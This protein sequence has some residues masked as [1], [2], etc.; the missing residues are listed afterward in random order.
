MYT[1]TTAQQIEEIK[2][3][4]AQIVHLLQRYYAAIEEY[5]ICHESK[6]QASFTYE[7]SLR[8]ESPH[9]ALTLGHELDTFVGTNILLHLPQNNTLHLNSK[10][11]TH[12]IDFI[13]SNLEQHQPL[14]HTPY[15]DWKIIASLYIA[16]Q[17]AQVSNT[18]E[19]I[20]KLIIQGAASYH[21]EFT[22]LENKLNALEQKE[23]LSH[24]KPP[25]KQKMTK[26]MKAIIAALSLS[27]AAVGGFGAHAAYENYQSTRTLSTEEFIKI[28]P[29]ALTAL[30][31]AAAESKAIQENEQRNI[32]IMLDKALALLLD[33]DS[34]TKAIASFTT[35]DTNTINTL[36][37]ASLLRFAG[38]NGDLEPSVQ[39][40][41]KFN[42]LLDQ[43]LTILFNN[44][45]A[46]QSPYLFK[47]QKYIFKYI[48]LAEIEKFIVTYQNEKHP[49]S[50]LEQIRIGLAVN[51]YS[52]KANIDPRLIL[53][54][55][56]RESS[57]DA[58]EPS[59]AGARGYMQIMPDQFDELGVSDY[60]DAFQNIRAGVYHLYALAQAWLT[61]SDN[62]MFLALGSYNAGTSKIS[63]ALAEPI[64]SINV[65]K[66][67]QKKLAAFIKNN[68]SQFD[69]YELRKGVLKLW[70]VMRL[71][72]K[73]IWEDMPEMA[74]YIDALYEASQ[75]KPY[76]SK[77]A[78]LKEYA[79]Q[80]SYKYSHYAWLLPYNEQ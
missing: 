56:W 12:L 1:K 27:A 71:N 44:A 39:T 68:L 19:N 35:A 9:D 17:F 63:K 72:E 51:M 54:I 22:K 73:Q 15:R 59:S 70:G 40:L 49:P 47:N 76:K 46:T 32:S 43:K 52:F 62:E 79:N 61:G 78:P 24:P 25:Q 69:K 80:I 34:P 48:S 36:L 20:E 5:V 4:K 31:S 57:F 8:I 50:A 7:A 2:V 29:E 45:E 6:L 14:P 66:V 42:T 28:T 55:I 60:R 65:A 18:S 58:D 11:L 64:L 30:K 13:Q 75:L 3:N 10:S 37:A 16:Y 26:T 23:L 77:Y 38:I 41:D 74:D 53:C 67:N 33:F 21:E